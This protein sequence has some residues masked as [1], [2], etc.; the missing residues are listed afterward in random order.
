MSK[1]KMTTEEKLEAAL[2]IIDQLKQQAVARF[3]EGTEMQCLGQIVEDKY[4]PRGVRP[5]LATFYAAKQE[6]WRAHPHNEAWAKRNGYRKAVPADFAAA[7]GA[8][9]DDLFALAEEVGDGV[10]YVC[11]KEH[12]L[13]RRHDAERRSAIAANAPLPE[14]RGPD[15]DATVRGDRNNGTS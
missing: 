2:K 15:G 13:R 9:A 5:E 12:Q 10:L 8:S 3:D 14:F 7:D 1:D 4:T 11:P 6:Q